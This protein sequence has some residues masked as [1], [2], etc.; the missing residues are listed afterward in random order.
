MP[1]YGPSLMMNLLST[2]NLT[3][4]QSQPHGRVL[5]RCLGCHLGSQAVMANAVHG[6]HRPSSSPSS[7]PL[8][9][10]RCKYKNLGLGS[11]PPTCGC[12]RFWESERVNVCVCEHH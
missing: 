1:C 3:M 5:R 6:T 12:Q 8:P 7:R 9:D 4:P 2:I 11:D 10:G